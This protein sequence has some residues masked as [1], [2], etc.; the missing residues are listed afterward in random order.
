MLRSTLLRLAE[1]PGFASFDMFRNYE[2]RGEQFEKL[3]R[4]LGAMADSLK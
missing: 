4:D 2:D 1:S 3:V